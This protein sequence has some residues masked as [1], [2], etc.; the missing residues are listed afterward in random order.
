VTSCSR[1]YMHKLYQK[2]PEHL[3]Y[4]DTDSIKSTFLYDRNDVDLGGLKLEGEQKRA[5]YLLPKTYIEEAMIPIYEMYD[6]KGRVISKK[7]SAHRVMKGFNKTTIGNFTFE[8]FTTALEG[9]LSM[10]R[11]VNPKKFATLKTAASRGT[12]LA[13]MAESPRQ[14]RTK[15]NKRRIVKTNWR[16]VYD[17]EPLHIKDGMIQN[18]DKDILKK[19]TP[20][21]IR[22]MEEI[23]RRVLKNAGIEL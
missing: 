17:T 3:Y 20:P 15:Y 4:T 16:Q 9:D 6:A 18:M 7:T 23:E 10:L 2:A 5:V 8:H 14:L 21:D 13:L 19:W 11:A 22:K 12:F 1:I